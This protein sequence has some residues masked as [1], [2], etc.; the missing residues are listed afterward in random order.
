MRDEVLTS[1]REG[2]HRSPPPLAPALPLGLVEH[3]RRQRPERWQRSP[4]ESAP[5]RKHRNP[6]E[7]ERR[8]IERQLQPH[9]QTLALLPMHQPA[10][11]PTLMQT[12]RPI[13][14][15][16]QSRA[17]QPEKLSLWKWV[18]S[19]IQPPA[20]AY[21]TKEWPW[22]TI[23]TEQQKRKMKA[24]ISSPEPLMAIKP[25]SVNIA[26]ESGGVGGQNAA[27]SLPVKNGVV[28]SSHKPL[29]A[30]RTEKEP[31]K[32]RPKVF[33]L[34]DKRGYS[35]DRLTT[36]TDFLNPPQIDKSF[37]NHHGNAEVRK[38]RSSDFS[39]PCQGVEEKMREA[40]E[41]PSR[42]L[43]PGKSKKEKEGDGTYS[44]LSFSCQGLRD[45]A[46][47]KREDKARPE[48]RRDHLEET[49][50]ERQPSPREELMRKAE[51]RRE[52]EE[53]RERAEQRKQEERRMQE[54]RR[55][56]EGW[57]KQ[58]GRMHQ[59][60]EKCRE[61]REQQVQR[62]LQE[63]WGLQKERRQ[64]EERREQT[65][66]NT[67]KAFTGFDGRQCA[68]QASQTAV[69]EYSHQELPQWDFFRDDEAIQDTWSFEEDDEV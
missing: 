22:R 19:S 3:G 12:A 46:A 69:R 41:V 34:R 27:V 35:P 4:E 20:E 44:D 49:W 8:G 57:R 6:D 61:E 53:R 16:Q 36:F 11:P 2:G 58:E 7:M 52:E 65:V 14:R 39:F 25:G 63:Q 51:E 37:L 62:R 5:M 43:K 59:E 48:Q 66:A 45:E 40:P 17:N 38:R 1:L 23:L 56:K 26:A 54:G 68:A 60:E 24:K 13:E 29:P 33:N 10:Q 18:S 67:E 47:R 32:K 64:Q 50:T 30:P 55:Q 31:A 9:P 15:E 28:I 42:I 21:E